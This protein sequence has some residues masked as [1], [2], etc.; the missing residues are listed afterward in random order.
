[1]NISDAIM[2]LLLAKYHLHAQ[3]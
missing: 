3:G 1:V 2:I